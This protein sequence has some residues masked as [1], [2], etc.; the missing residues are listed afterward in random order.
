MQ[1][2]PN[3]ACARAPR[4]VR[5][6][7]DGEHEQRY[8]EA[9]AAIQ[10]ARSRAGPERAEAELH[11]EVRRSRACRGLSAAEYER[12]WGYAEGDT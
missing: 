2:E 11:A 8:E 9:V 10:K 1:R 5:R 6:D 4:A 12:A 3:S 7:A